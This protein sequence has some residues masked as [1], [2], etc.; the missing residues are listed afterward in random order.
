MKKPAQTHPIDAK[1]AR[2]LAWLEELIDREYDESPKVFEDKTGIKMAQV[3]QWFSGYR[4][5]RDK[6]LA[7]LEEAAGKPAGYFDRERDE[8]MIDGLPDP[9]QG[10]DIVIRQYGAGGSMGGGV[11]LRDQPGVIRSWRVSPEWIQKNV[12][13]ATS[14]ANLAIVTGF[15]DSMRPM[16]NPGD[17]LLVDTGVMGVDFD[18]IYFFA[19]EG[20]GFIKRLQRVPGEGLVAISE[21]KAYRD[22]V[23]KP[24]MDF[25]V[26]GRVLRVWRGDDY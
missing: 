21:N 9:D 12:R 23:I 10:E 3:S 2:R 26:F 25:H 14:A 22:W 7:R 4:A 8:V 1:V 13:N 18:G 16:F 20:E 15:G 11:V 24:G 17:P 5:L 6:A 19:V